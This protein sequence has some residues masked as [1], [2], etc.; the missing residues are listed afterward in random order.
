MPLRSVINVVQLWDETELG[1]N[2]SSGSKKASKDCS[3]VDNGEASDLAP[4]NKPRL[5]LIQRSS[6][7][8][9]FLQL[10]AIKYTRSKQFLVP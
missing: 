3:E 5:P 1:C 8:F 10:V 4:R 9:S 6:S 7:I 2:F